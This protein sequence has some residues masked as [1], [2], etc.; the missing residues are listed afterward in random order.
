M[1]RV[2]PLQCPFCDNYLRAPLDIDFGKIELTGGICACSAVYVLDRTGHNLGAIFMD[3]LTFACKGEIDK[4]LSLN[5]EDYES[6]DYNYDPH[7]NSLC[8]TGKSCK[9]VFVR[10]KKPLTGK[11]NKN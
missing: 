8:R 3:A 4:A 7:S 5:P 9:L 2:N 6:V 1:A 11:N 10:L